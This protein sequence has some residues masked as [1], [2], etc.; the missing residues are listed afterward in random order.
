[1]TTGMRAGVRAEGSAP[2]TSVTMPEAPTGLRVK[3]CARCTT[4]KPEEGFSASMWADQRSAGSRWCRQ[5]DRAYH[6]ELRER[7][8]AAARAGAPTFAPPPPPEPPHPAI[9]AASEET[10][11][12]LD[13]TAP[14]EP[15]AAVGRSVADELRGVLDGLARERAAVEEERTRLNQRAVALSVQMEAVETTIALVSAQ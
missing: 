15:S 10:A 9:I 7:K 8:R 12:R 5:C 14:P 1:M 11:Q 4:W 2:T 13:E 3:Q 6:D